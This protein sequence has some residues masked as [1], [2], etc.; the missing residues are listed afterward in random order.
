MHVSRPATQVSCSVTQL[1]C[2]V[3]LPA[4]KLDIECIHSKT[5][6][7]PCN[8]CCKHYSAAPY[9]T[10]LYTWAKVSVTCQ[11]SVTVQHICC[12]RFLTQM[13]T[14]HPPCQH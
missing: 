12:G 10:Y 8:G 11:V 4:C 1:S 6:A 2:S 3:T 9:P 7:A 13:H 5:C 14:L